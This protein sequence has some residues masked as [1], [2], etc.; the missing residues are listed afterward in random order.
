ML[1]EAASDWDLSQRLPV[2]REPTKVPRERHGRNPGHSWPGGCQNSVQITA[3]LTFGLQQA[4]VADT[5][6]PLLI[7]THQEGGR[8]QRITTGVTPRPAQKALAGTN[9][10]A[11]MLQ[12][13]RERALA[14]GGSLTARQ[15]ADWMFFAVIPH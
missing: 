10:A 15:D 12:L 13:L 3:A 2:K 8:V 9:P 7:A 14:C 5:G 4:A 11:L 6:L 1:V